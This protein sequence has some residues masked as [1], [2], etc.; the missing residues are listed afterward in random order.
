MD[1]VPGLG[2]LIRGTRLFY[3]VLRPICVLNERYPLF[4]PR[5][6]TLR[7]I[8]KAKRPSSQP[9]DGAG[10]P[11][12]G[13]RPSPAAA[14]SPQASPRYTFSDL[15]GQEFHNRIREARVVFIYGWNFRAPRYMRRQA[16]KVRAYF[17]PLAKFEDASREAVQRLRR[18]AEV[19]VGVHVRHGNYKT[20]RGGKYL[21]PVSRYAGWM[22]EFAGQFPG[23]RVAFLVCSD[24]ARRT[25][26]FPGLA[27]GLGA[28]S[29]MGDLYG[30]AKCD[31]IFGPTSSYSQWASFHG[32]VPLFQLESGQDRLEPERFRVCFLDEIPE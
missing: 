29:P 27:V 1:A 5:V 30:L 20:W 19:V 10:V 12:A 18:D 2:R 31:Y 16:D 25:E 9:Q 22:K 32:N 4:G 28:G 17:R 11:P 13:M 21:F 24:E 3:R 26:E 6:L 23:R 14:S 7:E 15:E 8:T